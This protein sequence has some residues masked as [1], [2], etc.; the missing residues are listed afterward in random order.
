[1]ME[2]LTFSSF[3][4]TLKENFTNLPFEQCLFFGVWNAEYLYHKYAN[5]LLELED[6]EGYE[7][8]TDALAYLWD[9][10]DKTANIEEEEVDNQILRLH[11]ISLD[12]LDQDEAK[13]IGVVKL[14]ECLESGLV[15][16][17]EKNY[18]FIAACAYFPL[19]VADVIMTNEL[20]L[21]TNDP[22]KHIHHPLMQVEFEAEL[23]MM[24]YL[25]IY[26]D[27][28]SKEKNLFR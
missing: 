25:Q 3:D 15:Y 18:E 26:R 16:I 6:E 20:G 14:M 2:Q 8:L 22:N 21:D 27:V 11:D 24:E 5:H 7:I 28:S 1:M 23:K 12:Q 10:V 17:E 4:K 9:A 13:G 19:D